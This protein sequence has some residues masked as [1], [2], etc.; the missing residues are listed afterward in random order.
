MTNWDFITSKGLD[1]ALDEVRVEQGSTLDTSVTELTTK[2]VEAIVG[3]KLTGDFIA[4]ALISAREHNADEAD[5]AMHMF[6]SGLHVGIR[7]ALNA[8]KGEN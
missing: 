1:Q 8:M 2:I 3:A 4:G 5:K 6:V 7:L